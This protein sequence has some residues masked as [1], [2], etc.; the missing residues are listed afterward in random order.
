M[1]MFWEERPSVRKVLV[2]IKEDLCKAERARATTLSG[3]RNQR[4]SG[5][6]SCTNQDSRRISHICFSVMI[7]KFKIL[8]MSYGVWEGIKEESGEMGPH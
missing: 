8:E 3:T 1:M 2:G 7:I 6:S 5:G 4:P